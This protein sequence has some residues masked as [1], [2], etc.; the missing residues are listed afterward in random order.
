MGFLRSPTTPSTTLLPAFEPIN[1]PEAEHQPT[2]VEETEESA[3]ATEDSS[4]QLELEKQVDVAEPSL[5]FNLMD[6]EDSAALGLP[7]ESKDEAATVNEQEQVFDKSNEVGAITGAEADVIDSV[8]VDES[9]GS[10]APGMIL[11]EG[12]FSAEGVETG[13]VSRRE[14]EQTM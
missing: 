3:V 5:P 11:G 1:Q 12:A 9:E 10:V 2:V 6:D 4:S 8:K 7:S 14:E 13:E